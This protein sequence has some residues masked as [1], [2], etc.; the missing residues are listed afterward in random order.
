V[1]AKPALVCIASI[2]PTR[3]SEVRNYCRRLRAAIPEAK[4]LVLR[5]HLADADVSRSTARMK[6]AGADFVA[7]SVAEAVEAIGNLYGASGKLTALSE[8]NDVERNEVMAIAR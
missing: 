3:G 2:S 4:L 1:S 7:T 8:T 6:D 5:P